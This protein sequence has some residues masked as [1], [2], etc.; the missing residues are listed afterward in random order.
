MVF[1]KRWHKLKLSVDLMKSL[2][3][4]IVT[5]SIVCYFRELGLSG[6][7]PFLRVIAVKRKNVTD[8]TEGTLRDKLMD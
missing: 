2:V 4:F 3:T 5:K 6:L 1:P 7:S 8:E